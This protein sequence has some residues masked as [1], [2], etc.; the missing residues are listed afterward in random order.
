MLPNAWG[1]NGFVQPCV[2]V[3]S[4]SSLAAML[5]L[6]AAL[7]SKAQEALTAFAGRL[8]ARVEIIVWPVLSLKQQRPLQSSLD[9]L[10]TPTHA[11][12]Q[13]KTCSMSAGPHGQ[14]EVLMRVGPPHAMAC[15]IGLSMHAVGAARRGCVLLFAGVWAPGCTCQSGLLQHSQGP[16]VHRGHRRYVMANM[17]IA[18][19][20]KALPL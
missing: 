2:C 11:R 17:H 15:L 13:H 18:S 14:N 20:H 7:Q 16:A 3:G 9:S 19:W 5:L 10:H 12:A 6:I 8:A 1:A 4:C